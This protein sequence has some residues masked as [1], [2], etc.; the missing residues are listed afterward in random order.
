MTQAAPTL[1]VSAA[2][3]PVD[4]ALAPL[5]AEPF[6]SAWAQAAADAPAPGLVRRRLFERLAA[7]RAASD[8]MVTA[9]A[10]RIAAQAVAPDVDVR[11]LYR[12]EP[13]RDPRPGEP[14][15]ACLVEMAPGSTLP[16][17]TDAGLHREW[18]VLEGTVRIG[19]TVLSVRDY[20]VAPAG[21]PVVPVRAECVAR[22]F[23]RE[24]RLPAAPGDTPRTVRDADASWPEFAPGIQRRVLW[25]HDGEAALLYYAQPGARVPHH[26][27]RFDEECLMVQG[28]LFLD[29]VLLQAGDYQL[30]PAGTDHHLT[31]TDT[32]VVLFA[33]G[34][35]LPKFVG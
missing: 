8:A 15:R 4:P 2:P 16:A 14:L 32:G 21:S 17:P 5:L 13:G 19:D 33:H 31:E 3:D 30:A 35:L 29:D 7:S 28:E 22:L 27:H 10:A 34:D 12:A 1:A 18:L 23:L 20:H 11:T 25:E 26:T 24:A 9:R 6:A